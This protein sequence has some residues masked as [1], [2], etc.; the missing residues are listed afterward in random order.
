VRFFKSF[1]RAARSKFKEINNNRI[2]DCQINN[3][4]RVNPFTGKINSPENQADLILNEKEMHRILVIF[5][6]DQ[7]EKKLFSLKK[8]D[9]KKVTPSYLPGYPTLFCHFL[10]IKGSDDPCGE[11]V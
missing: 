1:D 7:K 2:G 9:Q 6:L 8:Q 11:L 3:N 5:C 10:F 4:S